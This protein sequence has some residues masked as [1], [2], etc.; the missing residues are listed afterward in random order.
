MLLLTNTRETITVA[1]DSIVTGNKDWRIRLRDN[2]ETEVGEMGNGY[3]CEILSFLG[4]C[5]CFGVNE[6][7]SRG[8]VLAVQMTESRKC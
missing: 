5:E 8:S 4:N 2:D 7:P 3:S 6:K 1:A